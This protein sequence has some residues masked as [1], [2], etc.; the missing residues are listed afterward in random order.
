MNRSGTI[1]LFV[2]GL[3]ALVTV[4]G[5]SFLRAV[6][7][8]RSTGTATALRLLAMR[9]AEAGAQQAYASLIR[10]YANAAVTVLDGQ[11]R[12][13]FR[14]HHKPFTSS[15]N[16]AIPTEPA[17]LDL[18]DVSPENLLHEPA[19]YDQ[20][21][22]HVATGFAVRESTF[23]GGPGSAQ[24]DG[25]GR[26]LEPGV[27]GPPGDWPLALGAAT[28]RLATLPVRFGDGDGQDADGG[29]WY[30]GDSE[31]VDDGLD[32]NRVPVYRDRAAPAPDDLVDVR[33]A[34]L[35]SG[36]GSQLAP[37]LLDANLRRLPTATRAEVLAARA[38]AR[39][40]L[41]YAVE[42]R[43]LESLLLINPDPAID[44]RAIIDPDP[45]TYADPRLARV[46]R[47]LHA[48]PNLFA[49]IA[50]R[51]G[52]FGSTGARLQHLF[53]GRGSTSSYDRRSDADPWPRAFPLMHRATD[54]DPWWLFLDGSGALG[55]G[56]HPQATQ[57]WHRNGD[58]GVA[59]GGQLLPSTSKSER[60]RHD[61]TG[62]LPSFQTTSFAVAGSNGMGDSDQNGGSGYWP[63][64]AWLTT[65][66]GR[67]D[68]G[69][70]SGRH[71]GTTGTPWSV[72]LLTA[73]PLVVRALVLSSL[74]PGVMQVRYTLNSS[75]SHSWWPTRTA[76]LWNPAHSS[77]FELY[78]VPSRTAPAVS[79]DYRV[80]ATLPVD[81][82]YRQPDQRY[83]GPL[84]FNGVPPASV[85]NQADHDALG[86]GINVS[87]GLATFDDLAGDPHYGATF[88]WASD[89]IQAGTHRAGWCAALPSPISSYG[90]TP[91]IWPHHDSIWCDVLTAFNQALAV[92]R[93]GHARYEGNSYLPLSSDAFQNDPMCRP[94]DL[95]AFDRLFLRCL[96]YDYA[97]PYG[98]IPTS[99]RG[100]ALTT[101]TPNANLRTVAI[102]DRTVSGLTATKVHQTQAA[103][104]AINDFRMSLFGSSA[105]YG[106]TF[107]PIDLN[108]DG[109]VA[110]SGY[111]AGDF[112]GTPDEA[113][114]AAFR[115]NEDALADATGFPAAPAPALTR[116]CITGNFFIGR[117]RFWQVTVRGELWDSL[118]Q[119]QAAQ[120]T[121][122]SVLLIDPGE[123]AERGSP[124]RNHASQVI[125]QRWHT[126][127]NQGLQRR[128]W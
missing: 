25:R 86:T 71:S 48:L 63:A 100:A 50:N 11:G 1:L 89:V 95:L 56:G 21:D 6:G 46:V 29:S 70:G 117:S 82:G 55:D 64:V 102:A 54:R 106:G 2:I 10:D 39:Y 123:D 84:L 47:Y 111:A 45:R 91:T 93:R 43:D 90:G 58:A 124:F 16:A 20:H 42:T 108:G 26:W 13:A 88:T 60:W 52:D 67:G 127:I 104:L 80:P 120:A 15:R 53:A 74:P 115:I 119:Q 107:Q 9:S 7:M 75:V 34:L 35:N 77:A 78:T 76:D 32:M 23:N 87:P 112:S 59:A 99:W 92:A 33:A 96:G 109:Y 69:L 125:F 101:F 114:R 51:S 116:W 126:N 105:D 3:M 66:F 5:W 19:W 65:P 8:Q 68:D 94:M 113:T 49:P 118:R 37:L 31:A 72:N 36:N 73:H 81:A 17:V 14:A 97:N 30:D 24:I 28:R 62:P 38:L 103:E 110:C 121:L 83:P 122:E 12:A 128:S 44:P 27:D 98:A 40:R 41:R 18:N 79:P 85:T 4:L 22:G 57:L 61:L